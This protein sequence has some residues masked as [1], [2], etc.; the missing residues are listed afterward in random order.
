[1]VRIMMHGLLIMHHYETLLPVSGLTL[2]LTNQQGCLNFH[3]LALANSRFEVIVLLHSWFSLLS[4]TVS[5]RELWSWFIITIPSLCVTYL[6]IE[7][8]KFWSKQVYLLKLCI[9]SDCYLYNRFSTGIVRKKIIIIIIILI[10]PLYM[11]M[12]YICKRTVHRKNTIVCVLNCIST[13]AKNR[14]NLYNEHWY[15][16]VPKSTETSQEGR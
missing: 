8:I 7:I 2:K 6:H 11:S 14:I 3:G 4:C 16:H 9:R 15:E 1:M 12:L 5:C 10:M 13:Y